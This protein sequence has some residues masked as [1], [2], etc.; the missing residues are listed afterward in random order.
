MR[1]IGT[2]GHVD[3]GKS[4]L[5]QALTG[6]DPDRLQEEKKRG[7]TIDLG[8]AWMSLPHMTGHSTR[9]GEMTVGIVDVPGHIDFIKNMLAGVGGIDAAIL[10]IAADEGVMPQTREHL[11]ILDLLAVPALLVA[12]TKVDA[13]PDAEWL[14][15]VELDIT[16]L[17]ETTRFRDAPIQRV[18]AL[19]GTGL[20]ELRDHLRRILSD[21]PPRRDRGLPRLPID[22]VFSLSGFGTIVTGT[23]QDG[24]VATGDAVAIL[25]ANLPARI[26][27]I[28]SHH[29]SVDMALPGSRVALNL[30][31]V[32]T[33]DL[34]RGDVVVKPGSLE[35]TRLVDV[36]FRLLPSAPKALR[37]NQLVEF[38]CGA[39][40][41]MAHV[42]LLGTEQLAPGEE[43][44]LQLRLEQPVVVAQGDRYILRRPSPSETLGGGTILNPHP[45]RRWRR[46]DQ[47]VVDRLAVL[48]K[49]DP[50]EVLLAALARAPFSTAEQLAAASGL[51]R[52]EA[53]A[54]IETLQANKTLVTLGG[55]D[56][57]VL[58]T[59]ETWRAV[60]EAL[61]ALLAAYHVENPLRQGMPRGEVR[62]R[63]AEL[64][65]QTDL[66]VRRFN[67]IITTAEEAEKVTADAST[68]RLP[69]FHA[70]P[71][72]Q[73]AVRIDGALEKLAAAGIDAP[74]PEDVIGWLG[75]DAA[76]FDYLL[77]QEKVVRVG[78]GLVYRAED[79][80]RYADDVRGY[81]ME[82]GQITLA[83]ARDL[84]Q[85]SRKYAQALLEEMDARRITRRVGD[86]RQ[87]RR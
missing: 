85:T 28:Q 53:Q 31:G 63:L 49:G 84:W 9:D 7:M 32:G 36:A 47:T 59:A 50:A 54:Q 57:A 22:R 33:E 19:Q 61:N 30:T 62:S 25:P 60:L 13:A 81:I 4:T 24:G 17:L 8:F 41:V 70:S 51:D 74:S 80:T 39:S 52:A 83:E 75:G 55:E 21:L 12:L 15:L 6:I 3:H 76:L 5:V 66:D 1:V 14:E 86:A 68:L 16:E 69:S 38:Y 73:Q 35:P 2:A 43:G 71:T 77:E 48:A 27:G 82:H 18:S 56:D 87:L 10:V 64:V 46:F 11:A 65:H 79:F 42:R 20:D 29:T 67:A 34:H 23:L 40:E 45:R 72:A 58:L 37:H 78:S 44:W 26:R